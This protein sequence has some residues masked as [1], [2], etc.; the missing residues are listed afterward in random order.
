M[1]KSKIFTAR[2][3]ASTAMAFAMAGLLGACA[4]QPGRPYDFSQVNGGYQNGYAQ[5]QSTT[6]GA[7]NE[8]T[9][10]PR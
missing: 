7:S 5:S 6:Y 1:T 2:R 3:A 9:Y 4:L 10:F 8:P